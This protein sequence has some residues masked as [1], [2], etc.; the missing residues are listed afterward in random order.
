VSVRRGLAVAFAL[1]FSL[2]LTGCGKYL[3]ARVT[4]ACPVPLEI[5]FWGRAAAPDPQSWEARDLPF[6][7]VRA[8]SEETFDEALAAPEGAW[9]GGVALVKFDG[10]SRGFVPI[11][12][13]EEEPIPVNVPI[14][15]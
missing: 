4:N 8:N 5:A 7:L 11:A 15:A 3:D 6:H 9:D 1:A 2:T 12:P 10:G 14:S 13:G